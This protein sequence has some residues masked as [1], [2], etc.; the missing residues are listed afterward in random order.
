MANV[1]NFKLRGSKWYARASQFIA[2]LENDLRG[3]SQDGWDIALDCWQDYYIGH[4]KE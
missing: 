1:A 2:N 4:L 3:I